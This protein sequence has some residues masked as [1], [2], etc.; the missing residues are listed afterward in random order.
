[1]W[2]AIVCFIVGRYLLRY[3]IGQRVK[4][5][6]AAGVIND[7]GFVFCPPRISEPDRFTFLVREGFRVGDGLF[8]SIKVSDVQ[9][10]TGNLV[11]EPFG[12]FEAN[13]FLTW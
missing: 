3:T 11:M 4:E 6:F 9:R 10:S 2:V 7:C 12:V 1:M 13:L 5:K 8:F